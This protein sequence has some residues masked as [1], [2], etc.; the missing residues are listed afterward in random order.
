VSRSE[1]LDLCRAQKTVLRVVGDIGDMQEIGCQ[2][3][4]TTSFRNVGHT[5]C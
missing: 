5:D 2:N 1:T 3:H 4:H